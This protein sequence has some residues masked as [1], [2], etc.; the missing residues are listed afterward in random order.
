MKEK[1]AELY[2]FFLVFL[3]VLALATFMFLPFLGALAVAFVLS[4][5]FS[6]VCEWLHRKVRFK[7]LAALLTLLL[8]VL[9]VFTPLSLVAYLLFGQAQDLFAQLNQAENGNLNGALSFI[10]VQ[11]HKV[12]PDFTLDVEGYAKQVLNWLTQSLGS[13]F[14]GT[15]QAILALVIGLISLFYFLRDGTW[16]RKMF[17]YYSPLRDTYDNEIVERVKLMVNSILRGALLVALIQGVLSGIGFALFGL[18]NAVLWGSIAAIGALIPGVGTSIVFVPAILFL[19][20]SSGLL[21]ALG[22]FAWAAFAVGLIDNFLGP[23]L[24]GRGVKVHPLFILLSVLGGLHLFGPVGFLL[25]PIV[26]SLILV[27]GEIYKFL[28]ANGHVGAGTRT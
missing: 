25:G 11:I 9:V 7:G 13:I 17:V 3:G 24:I 5:I 28:V 22:L 10:E 21:P 20:F 4:V 19:Y 12:A 1:K 14:A 16:F 18:P 27:F 6:P 26:L 23:I 8:I 15:A 2:F